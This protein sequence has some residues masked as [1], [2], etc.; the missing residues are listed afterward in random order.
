MDIK[1]SGAEGLTILLIIWSILST[2]FWMAV[3]WRAMSAHERLAS[4]VERLSREVTHAALPA[5]V[6][7]D[8]TSSAEPIECLECGTR[9]E[10]ADRKCPKCGWTYMGS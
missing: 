8:H 4:A 1:V 3:A 7:P 10:S 2:F 9:I 6:S 5:V